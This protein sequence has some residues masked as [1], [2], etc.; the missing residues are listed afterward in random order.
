EQAD[1]SRAEVLRAQIDQRECGQDRICPVQQFR[2]DGAEPGYKSRVQQLLI[3]RECTDE[4]GRLLDEIVEAAVSGIVG[5]DGQVIPARVVPGFGAQ[6]TKKRNV[7]A[8]GYAE[9]EC[10]PG[11]IRPA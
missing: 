7:K 4:E 5:R 9:D 8:A 1:S 10:Q 2:A 11:N 3:R 6:G